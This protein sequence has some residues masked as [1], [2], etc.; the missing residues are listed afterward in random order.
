MLR[1]TL[2]T[3]ISLGI[4]FYKIRIFWNSISFGSLVKCPCSFFAF[5]LQLTACI[6]KANQSQIYLSSGNKSFQYPWWRIVT[7][8]IIPHIPPN[9]HQ[10]SWTKELFKQELAN[11]LWVYLKT[12]TEKIRYPTLHI[13][14]KEN[15]V[16]MTVWWKL[17]INHHY[18]QIWKT[19]CISEKFRDWRN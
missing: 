3:L 2:S 6:K 19:K 1:K 7:V 14:T 18:E 9:L 5:T 8:N 15:T 13:W 12:G 4:Y 16:N 11:E 17:W 10:T